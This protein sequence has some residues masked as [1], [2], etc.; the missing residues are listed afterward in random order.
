MNDLSAPRRRWRAIA[1]GPLE[2]RLFWIVLAGL[3]PL[4]LLS[5]ATLLYNARTQREQQIKAAEATMRSVVTAVDAELR[6]SFASLDALATSPRLRLH[7]FEGFYAEARALLERRPAW[8]NIVLSDPTSQHV[9]N[10]RLPF[11]APLPRAIDPGAIEA[12]VRAGVPAVGNLIWSP[13][14]NMY[15]F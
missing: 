5:F 9:V 11:G 3:L 4:I 15:V 7:D 13:V 10:V 6:T 12:A 8:A 14:L 1:L 2:R